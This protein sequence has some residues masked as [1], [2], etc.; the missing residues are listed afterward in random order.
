MDWI[1]TQR[2]TLRSAT[3][4][5]FT[6][7]HGTSAYGGNQSSYGGQNIGDQNG[8]VKGDGAITSVYNWVRN[9]VPDPNNAGQMM[10][11]PLDVAPTQVIVV[12]T[13]TVSASAASFGT[14]G[15]AIATCDSGLGFTVTSKS[16]P[17]LIPAGPVWV[18]IGICASATSTGTR[19]KAQAG[20]NQIVLTCTPKADATTSKPGDG[21]SVT[22]TYGSSIVVPTIQILG[23]SRLYNPDSYS[24]ITGQ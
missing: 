22:V 4:G 15:T 5:Q 6:T 16:G 10:D 12:E 11:D 2:R 9:K 23:P 8:E 13:C 3:G 21:A 7:P 24:V 18:Q 1:I 19:Y 20:G 17:I 14:G